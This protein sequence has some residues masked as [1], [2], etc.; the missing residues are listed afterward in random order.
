VS[1]DLYLYKKDNDSFTKEQL[2]KA[3]REN[4]RPNVS[5]VEHQIVYE[6]ETTGVYFILD[7]NEQN[8]DHEDI[9]IF[10]SFEGFENLD[11][12]LSINFLRPD[13]FGY[14]TFKVFFES[15]IGFDVYILNSQELD[16]TKQKPL[17]WEQSEILSQWLRHNEMVSQ[18]QFEELG[19]SYYNKEKSDSVWNYTS[20]KDSLEEEILEDIFIPNISL[21]KKSLS[22]E[23]YSY[24]VWS[25]S[26]PLVLPKV[27]YV[28]ILKEYKKLFK[29]IEETGIINYQS[30]IEEFKDEFKPFD[31]PT[32]ANLKIL[33]QRSADSIRKR[34][35]KLELEGEYHS[36]G[37]QIGKDGFVNH[38]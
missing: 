35:N 20:I 37:N 5:E 24:V 10:D 28:I 23:V 6:N 21:I 7:L 34:F 25:Q 33:D 3:L 15:L 4:I 38:K 30:I 12:N 1:Y 36:F 27:D 29:T 14:E 32:C 18:K 13:Y 16:E 8:T 26:I 17:H 31:H 19:L 11:I 2:W 9:E 22:G